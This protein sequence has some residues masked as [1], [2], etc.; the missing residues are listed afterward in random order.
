M[1]EITG[2]T[3]VPLQVSNPNVRGFDVRFRLPGSESEMV[4]EVRVL[5]GK[6]VSFQDYLAIHGRGPV[7]VT[8]EV[9][10]LTNSVLMRPYFPVSN[11][12][13]LVNDDLG[14]QADFMTD[15]HGVKSYAS[16]ISRCHT[17]DL[18]GFKLM[19]ADLSNIIKSKKV[20]NREKDRAVIPVLEST[21]KLKEPKPKY[22]KAKPK[23][24]SSPRT[25]KRMYAGNG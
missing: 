3:V 10:E 19:V 9:A 20:A 14:L 22:A 1:V 4:L 24:K 6:V 18:W 15:I 12:Y 17:I 16:L 11:L 23:T 5:E 13:R 21:L 7:E 25:K 2:W 8:P